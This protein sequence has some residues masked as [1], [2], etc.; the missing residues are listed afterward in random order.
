MR[1]RQLGF[2][3]LGSAEQIEVQDQQLLL[4]TDWAE[5]RIQICAP[6][7]IR[8]RAG[9]LNGEWLD[10][11]DYA[12]V[13]TLPTPPADGQ[14]DNNEGVLT[15]TSATFC[16]EV[17][18]YPISIRLMTASGRLLSR[19]AKDLGIGKMG[20]QWYYYRD[21]PKDELNIGLGEKTGYTLRRGQRLVH[22]NTDAFMYGTDAD[23]L[24]VSTP[25]FI[26]KQDGGT[27]GLFVNSYARTIFDFGAGDARHSCIQNDRGGLDLFFMVGDSPTEV[28]QSYMKLTGLP[29]L[30]PRWS[31]GYQQCRYSYY[32]DHEALSVAATFRNKK[33]PCD[34]LYLDIHYMDQYKVF[35]W[36]ARDFPDPRGFV[37]HLRG[38]NFR[39]VV[40]L[41]PGI[42][43][44]PDYSVYQ[45][46]SAQEVF[47]CYPNGQAYS[48]DVWPGTCHF[49]DF[50]KSETRS[51]WGEEIQ[52]LTSLGISGYWN[53]M[54]EPAT[55]GKH[56]P[57]SLMF[58]L[59]GQ[60]GTHRDAHNVYG[61]QMARAT[62]EGV[63]RAMPNERAFIL[64]R[65]GFSGI[66]RYAAVWTGDN[67]ASEEHMLMG[68]RLLNSMGL[69]GMSFCGMDVGGFVGEASPDLFIRWMQIGSFS[70][71]FRGHSMINSR[72]SEPWSYGEKAEE[73]SRNFIRLRYK[74]LP[75]WYSLFEEA[76]RT[77][78]PA[79]R[80]LVLSYPN[81]QRVYESECAHQFMVGPHLLVA[82]V[83]CEHPY[84]KVYLPEGQWLQLFDGSI[85]NGHAA[86]VVSTPIDI[87]PVWVRAGA[88]LTLHPAGEH[89]EDL[90]EAILYL[91]VFGRSTDACS[92]YWYTDDGCS[93][94]HEQGAFK[95]RTFT[96]DGT[97]R[98][99]SISA[100]AGS[101]AQAYT[102]MRVFFHGMDD[103]QAQLMGIEVTQEGKETVRMIEPLRSYD[104]FSP[105]DPPF[106]WQHQDVPYIQFPWTDNAFEI[107]Y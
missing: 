73:I 16:L 37:D 24:Y 76:S 92:T 51:W 13:D 50:T 55:W 101:Y 1:Q 4:T 93:F 17:Q 72:D 34:V 52:S 40:I 53:D 106:P 90:P 91:H 43:V 47:L 7:I 26:G 35:T 27:Y 98:L 25:F 20:D 62:A 104:P 68:V 39:T 97:Q 10:E 23:P 75:Y 8:I 30:P 36:S 74:L 71:L 31:L 80:S 61:M 29:P 42:K 12:L 99:I 94:G 84:Q 82:A 14:W 33:I 89:T 103:A 3:P 44:D 41:D 22:W 9:N 21:L 85:W 58:H 6:E 86:H 64:T 46:G 48:G 78:L 18:L 59:E 69:A 63:R 19:D 28:L 45:R 107:R 5:L 11:A 79:L 54:N 57:D 66:Q 105:T 96:H 32:P 102:D 81:D 2:Q 70:P 67:T 15:Y 38:M 83:G 87:L 65:A 49:P 100:S 60:Q 88:I 95:C 77:G 56:L